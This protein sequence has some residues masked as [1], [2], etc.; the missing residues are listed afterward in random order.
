MAKSSD[1]WSPFWL[2][3]KIDPEKQHCLSARP[4]LD[5]TCGTRWKWPGL[6]Q[7]LLSHDWLRFRSWPVKNVSYWINENGT[8]LRSL[9]RCAPFFP[10][11]L[12]GPH[13]TPSLR[14]GGIPVWILPFLCDLNFVVVVVVRETYV[15][16]MSCWQ[17]ICWSDSSQ[18]IPLMLWFYGRR[19]I[20]S[21]V[22]VCTVHCALHCVGGEHKLWLR[23]NSGASDSYFLNHFL[24][25]FNV[26]GILLDCVGRQ[27]WKWIRIQIRKIRRYPRFSSKDLFLYFSP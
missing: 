19:E 13:P 16:C 18:Y 14:S 1:E 25:S 24:H 5:G 4:Y 17:K 22:C 23:V 3:H 21:C 6:G 27:T 26:E 20:S 2:H 15:R 7:E 8:Q 9:A 11:P 10:A 12:Q